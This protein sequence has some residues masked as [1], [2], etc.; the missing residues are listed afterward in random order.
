MNS[1]NWTYHNWI[2]WILTLYFKILKYKKHV[3]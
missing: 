2:I 1:T 3:L